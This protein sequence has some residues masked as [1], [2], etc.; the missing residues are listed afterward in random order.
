MT[1]SPLRTKESVP[2]SE[3]SSMTDLSSR[4]QSSSN[5]LSKTCKKRPHSLESSCKML[6][7]KLLTRLKKISMRSLRR[8]IVSCTGW[9]LEVIRRSRRWRDRWGRVLCFWF[10]GYFLGWFCETNALVT[11]L[12]IWI[13]LEFPW[14]LSLRES[15][16]PPRP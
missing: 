4:I 9:L 6:S 2:P 10:F 14:N 5:N 7:K 15:P 16:F 1:L 13:S 8:K 12:Y 3:T 11:V